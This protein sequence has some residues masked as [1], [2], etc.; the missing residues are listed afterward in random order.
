MRFE[1]KL[2][3]EPPEQ[4]WQEYCGFL[5]LPLEGYM[6]MQQHLLMEQITLLGASRLGRSL[7]GNTVPESVEEF[8]ARVPLTKYADYADTL[9]MRR[10]EELPATPVSWLET[11][12]EGGDYP[13]KAAP[14]SASMLNTYRNNLFAVLLLSHAS[15]KGQFHVRPHARVLYALAP[16]PY[17]TGLFPELMKGEANFQFMP[18]VQ[19]ALTLPFSQ[20]M[21][22]GLKLALKKDMNMF[23]GMSS[24]LY[25]ISQNLLAGS[26]GKTKLTDFSP[27]MLIRYLAARYRS[28]RDNTP[29]LPKDLFGLDT[30]VCV[31]NDST[32]Y[33]GE[34]ERCWGKKPLEIVGGTEP[35]LI[36]TETWSRDGLVLFPD[37]CFYEFIPEREMVKNLD[38]PGYVPRTYLM[39]ELS[40]NQLY[41]VVLTVLK[42]GSF[43]R[44]RVG[45]VFRC[46]RLKNIK[47]GIDF[48]QFEF[49]DRVPDVIDI[50]GFT[51]ITQREIEKVLEMSRLN[52]A[53]WSAFKEYDDNKHA[54]LQMFIELPESEQGSPAGAE[55]I[56][57]HLSVYFRYF[58]QDYQSLKKLIKVEPLKVTM[59]PTGSY[60]RFEEYAGHKLR[61][62]NPPAADIVDFRGICG[63]ERK[64]GSNAWQ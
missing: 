6:Q 19:E 22:Q 50:G 25:Y 55:V 13:R 24:L 63:L 17:A 36:A 60:R 38:D 47:D 16:L 40:P 31:G 21:S 46:L 27:K 56:K 37:A 28:R 54:Y 5:E 3:K 2:R 10:A 41:E 42:G 18:P 30:F 49:V 14:Y 57:E 53:C 20:Q 52:V 61:K 29:M 51:R 59:V 8:R 23:F 32:L 45:D 15:K 44:Y 9:L 11:T 34:L 4:L 26:D 1:A 12:W 62:I 35:G 64:G 48:P 7:M 33:K 43:I 58:D 39:N